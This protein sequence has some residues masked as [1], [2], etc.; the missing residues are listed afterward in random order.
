[1]RLRR[2]SQTYLKDLKIISLIYIDTFKQ[3]RLICARATSRVLVVE[4]LIYDQIHQK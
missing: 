2:K 3:M 4:N 1:M